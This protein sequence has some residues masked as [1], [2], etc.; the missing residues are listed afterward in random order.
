MTGCPD[1]GPGSRAEREHFARASYDTG[2]W[3]ADSAMSG[4]SHSDTP[5][6]CFRSICAAE[7][8]SGDPDTQD[9]WALPHH[10]SPGGPPSK[11]GVTAALGRVNQTEGI[12]QAAARAHLDKHA[13]L[14]GGGSSSNAGGVLAAAAARAGAMGGQRRGRPDDGARLATFAAQ[15]RHEPVVV[16]G[17]ELRQLDGYA[18]VVE[19]RYPMWDLFGEYGETVDAKAFDQT[20]A[21]DPDVAF[22]INHKGLTLARTKA[23]PQS[24]FLDADPR[25][26]HSS[27]L[28]N[29]KRS[30]VSDLLTAIDD[31]A[32]TEMSFAFYI[33]DWEW[34]EDYDEVRILQVD[35]DRGDVS[36]VNFG[37][38]PYTSISA[39]SQE[40]MSLIPHLPES[41]ARAAMERLGARLGVPVQV[42]ERVTG[43]AAAAKRGWGTDDDGGP[44]QV[45]QGRSVSLVERL[46][47]LD[48]ATR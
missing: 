31:G 24:L 18:S 3:D 33:V 48:S 6:S 8:S 45:G 30:D 16:N 17:K 1:T 4:C 9:H 28:V 23:Q 46:L 44:V 13:A 15:F 14:W 11:A 22:L 41:V 47:D 21:M 32:I 7:K 19:Q 25:G 39:R 35:I 20:L 37:A 29:P 43:Q 2:T 10:N 12:D 5:A 26:L 27:A 42:V 40:V 38:N 36:A 34:N